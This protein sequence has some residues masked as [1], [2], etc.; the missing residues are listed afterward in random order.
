MKSDLTV[1]PPT[2]N[3]LLIRFTAQQTGTNELTG[4]GAA[5]VTIVGITN[6]DYEEKMISKTTVDTYGTLTL[7]DIY[8]YYRMRGYADLRAKLQISGDGGVTWT[9]VTDEITGVG[10]AIEERTGPGLWISSIDVGTDK[11]QVRLIAKTVG[12]AVDVR[13]LSDSFVY[14]VYKKDVI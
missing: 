4:F 9:D 7:Q 10:G 3:R 6:T 13:V 1:I 2:S 11:F 12:G 5:D 14:I 8:F